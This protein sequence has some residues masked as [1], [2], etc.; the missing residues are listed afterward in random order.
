M[1][2]K[3]T[4]TPC[5]PTLHNPSLCSPTLH[6]PPSVLPHYTTLPLSS[7]TTL[8][9]LCPPTLHYPPSVLPH[10]I[11][12]YLGRTHNY[13]HGAAML[14]EEKAHYEGELSNGL[15]RS[16]VPPSYDG[17]YADNLHDPLKEVQ[18][19]PSYMHDVCNVM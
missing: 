15:P 1:S 5:P 13:W 19:F 2:D 17:N 8:P 3:M 14:M 16:R 4:P 12:Q 11:H 9:S 7:H 6:Y 10:Y 18:P